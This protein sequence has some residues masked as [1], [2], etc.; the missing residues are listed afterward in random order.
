MSKATN[1]AYDV[2]EAAFDSVS[3]ANCA[4]ENATEE[5]IGGVENPVF[6]PMFHNPA[7]THR[8]E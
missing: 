7:F 4:A 1:Y 8:Q 2:S 5:L 6:V 3:N